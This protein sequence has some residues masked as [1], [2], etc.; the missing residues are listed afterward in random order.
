M[1]CPPLQV[2]DKSNLFALV[3]FYRKSIAA[4]IKPIIAADLWIYENNEK[5]RITCYCQNQQG[6]KNLTQLI[7]RAYVE[8]QLD[9]CPTIRLGMAKGME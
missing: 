2:S 5:Y 6:Y 1:A 4:G 3:K 8:G 9:D 7:S